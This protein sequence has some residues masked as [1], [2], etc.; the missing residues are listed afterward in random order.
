MNVLDL[1]CGDD[2][3]RWLPGA[4]LCEANMVRDDI[5]TD[6][7]VSFFFNTEDISADSYDLV[8][9]RF[10]FRNW[11]DKTKTVE[12]ISRITKE[13]ATVMFEDYR[14]RE[15]GST[16]EPNEDIEQ[17]K[18]FWKNWNFDS[19]THNEDSTIVVMTKNWG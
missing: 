14:E 15:D 8:W 7:N 16:I 17:L 5:P 13:T 19:I 18:T 10:G 9:Y 1:G 3:E 11:G 12:E 2:R 4:D 6:L